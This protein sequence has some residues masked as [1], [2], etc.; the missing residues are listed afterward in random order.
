M[1][2]ENIL[3]RIA[4]ALE[5]LTV[6]GMA[7]HATSEPATPASPA[8]AS[9]AAPNIPETPL[10]VTASAPA[11]TGAAAPFSDGPGLTRYIMAAYQEMG[12][13]KGAQIQTVLNNLGYQNINDVKS[14]H[15]DQLYAGVEAMK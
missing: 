15:Y 11:A 10:P 3:E 14:E 8:P 5:A 9:P 6:G 2:I 4:V 1:T 13:E 7:A 12:Q